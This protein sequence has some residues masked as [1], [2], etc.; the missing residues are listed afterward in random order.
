MPATYNLQLS[1]RGVLV[2]PK[3]LREE[4]NLQAGDNLILF[5]LGDGVF[6]LKPGRSETDVLAERITTALIEQGE[7]LESMLHTLREERERYAGSV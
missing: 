2:L 5:D 4:Y 3:A 7:T 1:Q 6:V